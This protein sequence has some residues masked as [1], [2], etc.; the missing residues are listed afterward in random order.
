MAVDTRSRLADGSLVA[1][2]QAWHDSCFDSELPVEWQDF[3]V[4]SLSQ[5]I[6]SSMWFRSG[7]WRQL[8]SFSDDDPDPVHIHLYRSIPYAAFFP[9]LSR[10]LLLNAYA[11]NQNR[12]SG[13]IHENFPLGGQTAL[14]RAMGDTSTAFILDIYQ[15]YKLG[16]A[17]AS[18]LR[19]IWPHVE[20][21]AGFQMRNAAVFGLPTKLTTSY[22]WFVLEQHDVVAYN[23]FLHLSA[24]RA[25]V[26]LG[27]NL[28]T[29]SSHWLSQVGRAITRGEAALERR[30]WHNETVAAAGSGSGDGG[31]FAAIW[32]E[33]SAKPRCI[34]QPE[35]N[36]TNSNGNGNG[37]EG[38]RRPLLTDTLYGALWAAQLGLPLG[39]SVDKLRAHLASERRI[40]GTP[41]GLRVWSPVN[42]S[43]ADRGEA[44]VWNG[45]SMGHTALSLHLGE[46]WGGP[47]TEP[48]SQVIANYRERLRD[49]WDWK[50]LN[51]LGGAGYP[52]G[53]GYRCAT[54]P[55]SGQPAAADTGDAGAPWCNSHY[56]RQLIG[57][58]VPTALSGQQYDP[59]TRTLH[60]APAANAP[61]RLPVF[62]AFF[63]GTLDVAAQTLTIH[64]GVIASDLVVT[65]TAPGARA[66]VAVAVA[67]TVVRR[68]GE[69]S[70]AVSHDRPT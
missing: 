11:K 5:L 42:T 45:G 14:G 59:E 25:A 33:P 29:A 49:W 43:R 40:Q 62:T 3:L 56:T 66:P 69:G 21:A 28:H 47:G 1:D 58:A 26:A 65:M 67:V 54:A 34:D 53:D 48:A 24:L 7:S 10:D 63:T 60:F 55:P 57:W 51:S 2:I 38:R 4:N 12:S 9:E 6:K 39:A 27:T 44:M 64:A 15:L 61:V 30:L 19:L 18:Y 52:A 31:Y 41:F 13:Y 37:T 36:A 17:N 70:L 46:Q 8:E 16:G 35:C 22:D 50:D 23:A 32:D 20:A 68:A